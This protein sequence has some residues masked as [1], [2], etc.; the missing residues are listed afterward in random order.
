MELP[1]PPGRVRQAAKSKTARPVS[2]S[3]AHASDI[4]VEGEAVAAGNVD[5][6][7]ISDK[8]GFEAYADS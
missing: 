3:P 2:P 6:R 7:K 8:Q 5:G 1:L 4:V